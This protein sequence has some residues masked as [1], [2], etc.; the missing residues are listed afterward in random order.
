MTK[1]CIRVYNDI[2]NYYDTEC[3][4]AWH[5]EEGGVKENDVIFCP[6]CG[7]IVKEVK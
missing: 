7:R 3:G 1:R 4:I 2:D 6:F 5:F